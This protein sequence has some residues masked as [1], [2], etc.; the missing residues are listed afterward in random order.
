MATMLALSLLAGVGCGGAPPEVAEQSRG[1]LG[2]PFSPVTISTLNQLTQMVSDGNYL[3][4]TNLNASGLTWT[5]KNFTGTFDGGGHTISNLNIVNN[6]GNGGFFDTM[7]TAIVKNVR[8]INLRVTC[9]S[10]CGGLAG[11][12]FESQVEAVGV[13][14]TI[15]GGFNAGGGIFGQMAGGSLLRSYAK[16]AINGAQGYAGG[17]AGTVLI[18]PSVSQGFIQQCYAATTVAPDT[19]TGAVLNAG[20]LVGFADSAQISEVY[21]DGDVTG[22]TKVGGLI[23]SMECDGETFPGQVFFY[24]GIYRGNVKD[25]NRANG[26][27][28]GVLGAG[29]R[30]ANCFDRFDQLFWDTTRDPTLNQ[31]QYHFVYQFTDPSFPIQK[32]ASSTALR[33]PTSVNGG[34]YNIHDNTFTTQFWTAGTSM[35]H[36]ALVNMPGPMGDGL[37]IQPR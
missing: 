7:R 32:G 33:A 27:W 24:H 17:L 30:Q 25:L 36:H 1:A 3:L 18:G 35:Q 37:S 14:G 29:Q 28:S 16:G 9:H 8:F 12:S 20:G 15:T 6:N 11:V 23:G 13:E 5:P 4:S 19:S 21:A 2:S 10:N 31:D 22:R 26:S 34:V